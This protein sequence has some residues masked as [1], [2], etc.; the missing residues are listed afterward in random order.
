MSS[1]CFKPARLHSSRC[2]WAW[3]LC[4]CTQVDSLLRGQHNR[5]LRLGMA[6]AHLSQANQH[7]SR[8]FILETRVETSRHTAIES[9]HMRM[10]S[11]LSESEASY[12]CQCIIQCPGQLRSITVF[13]NSNQCY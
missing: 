7:S 8:P 3:S 9:I 6:A 11:M 1:I 10:D 4:P 5:P 13:C 12:L 2:S